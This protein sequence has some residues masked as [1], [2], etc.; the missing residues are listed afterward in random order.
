MYSL[1]ENY[2]DTFGDPEPVQVV[3]GLSEY[4]RLLHALTM[5]LAY[6]KLSGHVGS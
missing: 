6:L 3:P 4:D 1:I 5:E 2:C